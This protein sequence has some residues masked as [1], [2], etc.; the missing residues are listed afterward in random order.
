VNV[1]GFI[2]EALENARSLTTQAVEG[3][4]DSEML[5]QPKAGLNN[6]LWLLGH[7]AQS[8][9]GLIL[10]FCTG[11]GV[12][13]EGWSEKF[14]FGSKPVADRAAYPTKDEILGHLKKTHTA[15]IEYVRS[16]KPEDLDKRPSGIDRLS[17]RAQERF[18]TVARCMEHHITHESSHAGQITMLRRLLGKTPRV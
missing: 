10:G 14:G 5:F 18:S 7:I 12:L 16:L 8:E 17:P 13:P 15:A 2:V 3:L 11:K 6:A 4:T 1:N 9:N